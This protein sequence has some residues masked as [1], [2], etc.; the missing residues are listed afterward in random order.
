MSLAAATAT[1]AALVAHVAL[2]GEIVVAGPPLG[3]PGAR[4]AHDVVAA[5]A[6]DLLAGSH[7]TPPLPARLLNSPI[8][9]ATDAVVVP[10]IEPRPVGPTWIDE[11]LLDLPPPRV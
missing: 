11:R 2:M 1:V 5:A 9:M 10:H 8:D 6:R 4:C 7:A 3:V